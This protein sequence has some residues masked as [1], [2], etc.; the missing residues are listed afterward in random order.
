MKQSGLPGPPRE[1]NEITVDSGT[2]REA[3]SRILRAKDAHGVTV[4]SVYVGASYEKRSGFTF[5]V[6]VLGTADL[7]ASVREAAIGSITGEA[8]LFLRDALTTA[9]KAGIPVREVMPD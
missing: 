9:R 7:P 3:E 8:M 4:M 2:P 5:T 6:E 1:A